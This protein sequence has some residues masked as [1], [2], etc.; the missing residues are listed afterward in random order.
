L[1][2][3]LGKTHIP[4]YL[5]YLKEKKKGLT[6]VEIEE[7]TKLAKRQAQALKRQARG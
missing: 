6:P 2:K 3:Y 4:A 1:D 7:S 5:N